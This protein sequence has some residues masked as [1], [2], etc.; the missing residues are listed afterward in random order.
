MLTDREMRDILAAAFQRRFGRAGTRC[1]LQCLQAVAWL[2][3]SYGAGWKHPGTNSKNLGACQATPS[4][5]GSTFMYT[6]THPTS[7]GRNVPYTVAFRFY[8]TW[9][10]SADDL[11]KIVYVN[12]GRAMALAA[13]GL[14]DTRAF[15]A[16]LHSTRYYEGFGKTVGERIA[17]HHEAVVKA[18]R[19]QAKAL[20]EPLPHDIQAMP[21]PPPTLKL[22]MKGPWVRVMQ[23][24]LRAAGHDDLTIDGGFGPRTLAALRS[25]QIDKGLVP[26]GVAGPKTWLDLGKP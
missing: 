17:H 11:V 15:S 16:A 23:E 21:E 18:I 13:A 8:D 7:D 12:A 6:D 25:F 19:R 20:G 5:K 4:W 3:T 22:G 9:E 10:Q 24:A 2:E 14:E 1:E 26:D